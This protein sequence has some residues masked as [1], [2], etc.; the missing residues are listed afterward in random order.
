M[1]RHSAA[2]IRCVRPRQSQYNRTSSPAPLRLGCAF[3]SSNANLASPQLGRKWRWGFWSLIGTQFQGAFNENCLKFLTI[4]LILAAK[5]NS[6]NRDDLEFLVG[7]LF[8]IPF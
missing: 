8:A 5:K 1:F 3:M 4:Y 7:A 2:D 6:A